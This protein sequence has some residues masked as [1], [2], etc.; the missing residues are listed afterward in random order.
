MTAANCGI[1]NCASIITFGASETRTCKDAGRA[2]DTPGAPVDESVAARVATPPADGYG[3]D[4]TL[5]TVAPKK[6]TRLAQWDVDLDGSVTILD[7]SKVAS[8]YGNAINPSTADPR[9]EG[10]LDGDNVISILDLSAM[11]QNFARS[12]ANNCRIE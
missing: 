9:W 6:T 11:A 2:C 10:T 7:L 4:V 5:D 8:W 12:V 3:C 1:A